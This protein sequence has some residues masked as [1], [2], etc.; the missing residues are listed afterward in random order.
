MPPLSSEVLGVIAVVVGLLLVAVAIDP[1]LRA[2]R[3][4][5]RLTRRRRRLE[6]HAAQGC[7]VCALDL[8][9]LDFEAKV[10]DLRTRLD[11]LEEA[12]NR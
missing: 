10:A 11:G 4:L 2:R 9:V 6:R 3:A 1:R 8:E 5:N 12:T 7:R